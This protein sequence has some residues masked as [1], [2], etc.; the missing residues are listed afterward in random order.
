MS[1]SHTSLDLTFGELADYLAS[2]V[3]LT[4]IDSFGAIQL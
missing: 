2:V 1:V 3:F 4:R